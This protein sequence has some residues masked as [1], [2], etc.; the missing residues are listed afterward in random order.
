[1]MQRVEWA[2]LRKEKAYLF[3]LTKH[4][5]VRG[6][7]L[8]LDIEH[9]EVRDL[10]HQLTTKIPKMEIKEIYIL[11]YRDKLRIWD[12]NRGDDRCRLIN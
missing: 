9:I 11:N 1:M 10:K 7:L 5:E 2:D 3:K 4:R 8:D 12:G 6:I